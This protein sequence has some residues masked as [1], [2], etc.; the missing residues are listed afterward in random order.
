M[1]AVPDDWSSIPVVKDVAAHVVSSGH[2]QLHTSEEWQSARHV[3]VRGA[4]LV[5]LGVCVAVG[6]DV[7][8]AEPHQKC[9]TVSGFRQLEAVSTPPRDVAISL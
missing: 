1:S 4:G 6:V 2:A 9:V 3:V 5:G 7:Q 8:G